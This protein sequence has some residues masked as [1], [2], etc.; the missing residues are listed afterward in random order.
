ME[1]I[2]DDWNI[3]LEC[4]EWYH[5]WL[6]NNEPQAIGEINTIEELFISIPRD[7]DEFI[8]IQI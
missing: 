6:K 4:L 7:L 5:K 8:E 3:M 1:P 2:Q